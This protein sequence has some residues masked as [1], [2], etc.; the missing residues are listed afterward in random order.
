MF[1]SI[2]FFK[3]ALKDFTRALQV[4]VNVTS[5]LQTQRPILEEQVAYAMK[6]ST[7]NLDYME[8]LAKVI[9][10]PEFY[11]FIYYSDWPKYPSSFFITK[12]KKR[13]RKNNQ[14]VLKRLI[15]KIII[16]ILFKGMI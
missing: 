13:K 7:R 10:A 11:N 6:G 12:K 4:T 3:R 1:L 16:E 2:V 8:L 5:V 14:P 9:A 15:T